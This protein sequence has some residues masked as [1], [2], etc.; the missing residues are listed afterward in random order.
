MLFWYGGSWL[1]E[2]HKLRTWLPWTSMKTAALSRR[3]VWNH[4]G[5][6]VHALISLMEMHGS[7]G[8]G[9]DHLTPEA[10]PPAPGRV[11][12][13]RQAHG[14]AQPSLIGQLA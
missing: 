4:H 3:P 7:S 12:A 2:H 8:S 5:H 1:R 14:E 11:V 13:G 6:P 9:Q 10:T